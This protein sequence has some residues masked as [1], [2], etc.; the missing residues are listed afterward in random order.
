MPQIA[1]E[2]LS[3]SF[4][5]VKVIDTI[6]AVVPDKAFLVLVGPSGCG[7]STMLR[8]IAGLTE[9][10]SGSVRFDGRPMENIEPRARDLA[11]VFQSYALYPH[12]TIRDN[13]AFPLVMQRFRWWYHIPVVS[14]LMRRRMSRDPAITGKVNAVAEMLRLTP[15]LD[16]RPGQLSGGQRQR[17]AV[18]RALVREP[19]AYLLDEPLSNLD[20]ALRTQMRSEIMALHRSVGKTFIYVTHD[21]VEAMT[22]GTLIIVLD[23]GVVQQYATPTE[24][25]DRPANMF[26]ARF[27]GVPPMNLL[28]PVGRNDDALILAGNSRVPIPAADRNA[29]AGRSDIV[30]G[31]RPEMIEVT[32]RGPGIPE[33]ALTG[34]IVSIEYLGAERIVGFHLGAEAMRDGA[35]VQDEDAL[36]YA[37][38]ADSEL[39]MHDLCTV[40]LNLAKA[41]YFDRASGLRIETRQQSSTMPAAKA[42]A[43][44]DLGL[45]EV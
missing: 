38:T 10:T 43:R 35:I 37:R 17:V 25:Y 18:A 20:A 45:T 39:A 41:S 21:Q 40:R 16:R 19:S 29:L 5:A 31:L 8:M 13:I 14:A 27:I 23:K 12:L 1:F 36:I 4:G 15:L 9:V 6:N 3:K 7:K 42:A 2:N 22:M 44:P 33:D 32:H 28:T 26:V 34:R 30:L 11:F 24:I